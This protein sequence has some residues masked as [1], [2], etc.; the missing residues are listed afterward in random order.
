MQLVEI[1]LPLE[2]MLFG[3]KIEPP[4]LNEPIPQMTAM[5]PNET[6]QE[7]DMETI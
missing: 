7:S 3:M 5:E 2:K 6:R 4:I 1:W